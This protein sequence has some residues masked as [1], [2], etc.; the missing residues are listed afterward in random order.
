MRPWLGTVR[1]NEQGLHV[2]NGQLDSIEY[3]K[4]KA[5]RGGSGGLDKGS[6]AMWVGGN[7]F[8]KGGHGGKSAAWVGVGGLLTYVDV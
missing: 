2:A 1:G 6:E 3:R 7:L 4:N 8:A 5:W